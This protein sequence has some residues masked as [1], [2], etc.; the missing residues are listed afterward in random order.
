MYMAPGVLVAFTVIRAVIAKMIE[1]DA[2]KN[3]EAMKVIGFGFCLVTMG[4][5][6]DVIPMNDTMREY[7][8]M[9]LTEL[10]TTQHAGLRALLSMCVVYARIRISSPPSGVF[11]GTQ[12]QRCRPYG[13]TQRLV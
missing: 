3:Q 13:S 4:I 8:M 1:I 12:A 10:C 5:V 11:C 2:S 7:A 9:G 6:S